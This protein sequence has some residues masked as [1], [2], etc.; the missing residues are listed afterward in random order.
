M[1]TDHVYVISAKNRDGYYTP[2]LAAPDFETA[3]A[4]L[5]KFKD[6]NRENK[7]LLLDMNRLKRVRYFNREE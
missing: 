2:I 7:E 6:A 3:Q 1:P 4:A 5:R